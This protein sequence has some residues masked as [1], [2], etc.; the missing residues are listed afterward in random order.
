MVCK[1]ICLD[2]GISLKINDE[3]NFF[4]S[5]DVALSTSSSIVIILKETQNKKEIWNL[6]YTCSQT[7]ITAK[8]R[9]YNCFYFE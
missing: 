5:F 2:E 7:F 8:V 1:I 4:I 6:H 3:E 9:L